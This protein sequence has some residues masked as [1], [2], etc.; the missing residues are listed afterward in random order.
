VVAQDGNLNQAFKEF[1]TFSARL[2][3][4]SLS[5]KVDKVQEGFGTGCL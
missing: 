1:S 2:N 3:D 5:E 4:F